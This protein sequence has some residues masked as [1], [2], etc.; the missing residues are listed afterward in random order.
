ME[1]KEYISK[2]R[3]GFIIS[4]VIALALLVAL[5]VVSQS[6]GLASSP[7]LHDDELQLYARNSVGVP[8]LVAIVAL[9]AQFIV[10]WSFFNKGNS[11]PGPKGLEKEGLL[12]I[13]IG[14]IAGVLMA[15]AWVYFQFFYLAAILT[16]NGAAAPVSFPLLPVIV[17]IALVILIVNMVLCRRTFRAYIFRSGLK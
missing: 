5:I 2:N 15:G 16:A 10:K 11:A 7:K 17:L 9:I 3:N 1:R 6:L 13:V 4:T 12:Y 8:I 14:I